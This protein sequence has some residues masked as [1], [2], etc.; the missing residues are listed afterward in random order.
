MPVILTSESEVDVRLD[1][2]T[3]VAMELQRLLPGGLLK[4]AVRGE[5]MDGG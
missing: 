4:I 5:R 1:A 3:P 2:P